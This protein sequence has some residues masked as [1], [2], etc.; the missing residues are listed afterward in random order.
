MSSGDE[1]SPGNYGLKDQSMA[2]QWVYENIASF[3][4][5]PNRITLLGLF[6]TYE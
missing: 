1:N 6:K 4:G 2:I 3:G 5:D